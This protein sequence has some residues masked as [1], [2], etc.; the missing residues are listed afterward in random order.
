M[1]RYQA[2]VC[3]VF[4]MVIALAS[5]CTKQPSEPREL[6]VALGT[7]AERRSL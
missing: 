5:A 2:I 4:A 7:D 3:L 1:G 6:P